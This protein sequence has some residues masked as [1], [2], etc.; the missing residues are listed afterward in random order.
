MGANSVYSESSAKAGSFTGAELQSGRH[1]AVDQ[2]NDDSLA[3]V[4]AQPSRH[5]ERSTGCGPARQKKPSLQ[6]LT[7]SLSALS[8]SSYALALRASALHL[9]GRDEEIDSVQLLDVLA[10]T[11][12]T[13]KLLAS[14]CHLLRQAGRKGGMSREKV[15]NLLIPLGFTNDHIQVLIEVLEWVRNGSPVDAPTK[16]KSSPPASLPPASP[17]ET[18]TTEETEVPL[19]V[20]AKCCEAEPPTSPDAGSTDPCLQQQIPAEPE[21]AITPRSQ[22]ALASRYLGRLSQVAEEA[23]RIQV[24]AMDYDAKAAKIQSLISGK[25]GMMNWK[26]RLDFLHS[27]PQVEQATVAAQRRTKLCARLQTGPPLNAYLVVTAFNGSVLK[28]PAW[29]EDE[30]LSL[31]IGDIVVSVGCAPYGNGFK[32]GW[33]VGFKVGSWKRLSTDWNAS[34]IAPNDVKIFPSCEKYVRRLCSDDVAE[35]PDQVLDALSNFDEKSMDPTLGYSAVPRVSVDAV[36]VTG[37]V[38]R[39]ST[40]VDTLGRQTQKTTAYYSV[41]CVGPAGE[42]WTVQRRYSEFEKLRNDV[43]QSTTIDSNI[44]EL[45]RED[46]A[47]LSFPTKHSALPGKKLREARV[48]GFN[49]WLTSVHAATS[50]VKRTSNAY[51]LL[52]R[53]LRPD[54]PL[55]QRFTGFEHN[56]QRFPQLNLLVYPDTDAKATAEYVATKVGIRAI[57]TFAGQL[58]KFITANGR[59]RLEVD[60]LVPAGLGV[61]YVMI[62]PSDGSARAAVNRFA[63]RVK[64]EFEFEISDSC[65]RDIV[66]EVKQ[67]MRRV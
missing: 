12:D 40:S 50:K 30:D 9:Q 11:T 34:C 22:A 6:H 38:C 33:S 26:D 8:L 49:D 66:D 55:K 23:A 63:M 13:A 67:R 64:E 52:R 51:I 3:E 59:L 36:E 7:A 2:S 48:H 43:L 53:F 37:A 10:S 45:S 56:G 5:T 32:K 20:A 16:C 19:L 39:A 18:P 29:R 4:E 35:L 58:S 54:A 46:F 42:S 24:L 25:W 31:D 44:A 60:H 47:T 65:Q 27:C 15:E 61:Q 57:S 62:L 14:C 28:P 21:E 17:T 41:H 1:G